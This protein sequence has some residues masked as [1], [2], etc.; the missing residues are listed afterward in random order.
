MLEAALGIHEIVNSNMAQTLR[1]VSIKQGHDPREFVLMPFGG[2][3][4]IH[5]GELAKISSIDKI[6]IPPTPGVLSALG[7]MLAPI[8][9]ESMSS[10]EKNTN[11]SSWT[12]L[13]KIFKDLDRDC[14]DKMREDR[15]PKQDVE[16][17]YYIEMRYIGQS[18]E[19]EVPIQIK[20]DKNSITKL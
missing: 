18:H 9:H 5:S 12:D 16:K 11:E 10:F 4:P 15:V 6:L 8:Q 13:R 1:L 19:I 14:S 2:A 20:I 17:N 3:G 7:L